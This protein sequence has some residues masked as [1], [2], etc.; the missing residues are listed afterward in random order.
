V[1]LLALA[2][3]QQSTLPRDAPPGAVDQPRPGSAPLDK[4]RAHL[5]WRITV[6]LRLDEP[7]AK[8]LFRVLE[9]HDQAIAS[10]RA[11]RTKLRREMQSAV[12]RRA[13][14]ATLTSLVDRWLHLQQDRRSLHQQ[15]WRSVAGLLSLQQQAQLMLLSWR[16]PP[17]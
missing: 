17:R 1:A 5:L 3:G 6:T 16:S 15:K 13:S 4:R 10:F 7:T 8:K 12:D 2:L 11:R 14:A 9:R